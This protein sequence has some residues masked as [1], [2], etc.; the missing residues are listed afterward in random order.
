[1]PAGFEDYV[2]HENVL[3]RENEIEADLNENM[4]F[5]I[6]KNDNDYDDT[7]INDDI[8]VL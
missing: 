2:G 4:I 6:D 8:Y 7:M 3:E 5:M 1:V